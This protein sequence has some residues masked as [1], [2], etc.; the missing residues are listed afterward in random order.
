[1][2]ACHWLDRPRDQVHGARDCLAAG[3]GTHWERSIRGIFLRA[4]NQEKVRVNHNHGKRPTA[5]NL[6]RCGGGLL[7]PFCLVICA[8]C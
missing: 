6:G 5:L 4:S 7:Q 8:P 2:A 1:M 3:P